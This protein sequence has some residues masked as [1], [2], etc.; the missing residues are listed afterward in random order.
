M[1]NEKKKK[2]LILV[3]GQKKEPELLKTL[4]TFFPELD[5]KYKIVSYRTHIYALY[6]DLFIRNQADEIDLLQLLKER[7]TDSTKKA[8][9]DERYTDIL[10]VFDF[11]PHDSQ[12][13]EEK[14]R[15]MQAYFCESSDMGQLYINYPMIEAFYHLRDLPDDDFTS[16][17]VDMSVLREGKYKELVGQESYARYHK[18]Y[19]ATRELYS[20]IICHHIQKAK[21]IMLKAPQNSS[22]REALDAVMV[23]DE[24]VK[25]LLHNDYVYV[26]CTCIW[27]IYEYN[28]VIQ[29]EIM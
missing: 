8:I 23:L 6:Q 13:S 27:F 2:I 22:Q 10:L 16:R 20:R 9:F 26:L 1:E 11:E 29:Q 18:K 15:R 17:T 19:P 3:E 25:A 28:K 21:Q 7:E 12:F 24:Q 5:A 14:I 4:F